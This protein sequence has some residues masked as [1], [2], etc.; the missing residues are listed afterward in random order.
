M[1]TRQ[2]TRLRQQAYVVFYGLQGNVKRFGQ[3]IDRG[4]ILALQSFDQGAL[5]RIQ[6][7]ILIS[8]QQKRKVTNV[9]KREHRAAILWL[10]LWVYC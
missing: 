8:K 3:L 10:A 4:A 1:K 6:H 9:L 7:H 5:S 2:Q